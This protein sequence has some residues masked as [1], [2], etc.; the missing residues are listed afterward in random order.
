M[1]AATNGIQ[2]M[3]GSGADGSTFPHGAQALEFEALVKRA[4]LTP[5]KA[6]QSGTMINAKAM[7]WQLVAPAGHDRIHSRHDVGGQ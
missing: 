4:G 5:A 6:I 3:M 2:V 1:A 7:G